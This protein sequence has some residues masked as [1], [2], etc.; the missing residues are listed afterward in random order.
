M[1]KSYIALALVVTAVS[2][3]AEAYFMDGNDL[4]R[5]MKDGTG[6]FPY[7]SY[8]GYV[9]GIA[10]ASNGTAWCPPDGMTLGQ[11]VAITTK[12]LNKNPEYWHTAANNL[13]EA[14][15]NQAFPCK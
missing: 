6:G 14:A 13:V 4:V 1:S 12:Y 8:Y 10:D 7:G 3:Q 9:T 15:L 2:G 11:T 5:E